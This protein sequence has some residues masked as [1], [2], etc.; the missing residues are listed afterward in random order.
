M[1]KDNFEE[2]ILKKAREEPEFANQNMALLNMYKKG[3]VE[4]SWNESLGD[5]D[6]R[7]TV[8]GQEFYYSSLA[9]AFVPAE[10]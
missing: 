10:A 3:L 1:N 4:V 6:I 8:L 5:Y 9:E 2:F 7:A